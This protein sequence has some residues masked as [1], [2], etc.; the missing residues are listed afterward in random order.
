MIKK[1]AT[2]SL[3]LMMVTTPLLAKKKETIQELPK[4]TD[5]L[6]R[7]GAGAQDGAYTALGTSML[8]WG[9]GLAAGIGLLAAVLHQSTASHAHS[10]STE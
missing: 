6:Y 10:S 1:F 8:G 2:L 3:A 5:A 4:Q 7:Q 9:A